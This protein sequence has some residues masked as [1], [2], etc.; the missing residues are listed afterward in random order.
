MRQDESHSH[1]RPFLRP[2]RTV[3]AMCVRPRLSTPANRAPSSSTDGR[4]PIML[5]G[6]IGREMYI[7]VEG[8]KTVLLEHAGSEIGKLSS[9]DFFGE[10][11]A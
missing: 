2:L 10:L 6:E 5:E 3:F 7:V 4:Q 9:G 11:G 1:V 8:S